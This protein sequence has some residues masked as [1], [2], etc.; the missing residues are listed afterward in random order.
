MWEKYDGAIWRE[1]AELAPDD[2]GIGANQFGGSVALSDD[3]I[4]ISSSNH[5]HIDYAPHHGVVYLFQRDI[6][7]WKKAAIIKSPYPSND[8]GFGN[9]PIVFSQH[10]LAIGD[11]AARVDVPDVVSAMG[12][13]SG[14]PGTIKKAAAVFIYE[15]QILQG[16][17]LAPDPVDGLN[18][19]GSTDE[20]VCSLAVSGDTVVIGAEGKDRGTGAVYVWKRQNNQWHL[21]TELKGF[22]AQPDFY[23]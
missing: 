19:L 8:E 12:E 7:A 9:A 23:Y 15:N 20:Y 13:K 11:S 3:L 14:K 18:H 2:T 6:D 17:L 5:D 16:I 22:H 21:D 4:A 1:E 10:T